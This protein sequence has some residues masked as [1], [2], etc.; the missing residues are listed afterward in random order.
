VDV[1]SAVKTPTD[2]TLQSSPVFT[3]QSTK[4]TSDVI[5]GLRF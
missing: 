2:R 1:Y 5:S 3:F 4:G